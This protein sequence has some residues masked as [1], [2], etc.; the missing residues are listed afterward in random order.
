MIEII[1]S[2]IC[3]IFILIFIGIKLYRVCKELRILKYSLNVSESLFWVKDNKLKYIY[4]NMQT[5]NLLFNGLDEK[6]IKGKTDLEIAQIVNKKTL[7]GF[8]DMCTETDILT[9]KTRQG[10]W[11]Y[12]KS[13]IGDRPVCIWVNKVPIIVKKDC[14]KGVVGAAQLESCKDFDSYIDIYLKQGKITKLENNSYWLLDEELK[15]EI[16]EIIK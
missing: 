14:I 4:A 6:E 16:K 1:I 3:I 8:G 5:R 9:M 2:H 11:F 15:A 7:T 13:F 10:Q 12:E